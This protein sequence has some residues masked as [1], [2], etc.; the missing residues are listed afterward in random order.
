MKI[1]NLTS[2]TLVSGFLILAAGRLAMA[3]SAICPDIIRQSCSPPCA[4]VPQGPG[5]FFCCSSGGNT[6]EGN[7]ICCSYDCREYDC[8]P[9]VF[10]PPTCNAIPN[11]VNAVNGAPSSPERCE[12]FPW[13]QGCIADNEDT[14]P[15]E[16]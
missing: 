14:P 8:M 12:Q 13:G 4:M 2:I 11:R 3:Q 7:S 16:G 15:G 9:G 5:D 1:S 10:G 6:P